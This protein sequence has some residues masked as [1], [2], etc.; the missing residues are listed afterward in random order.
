MLKPLTVVANLT[1]PAGLP[2]HSAAR[3]VFFGEAGD[4]TLNAT[5]HYRVE[6][7]DYAAASDT[8]Y[9]GTGNDSYV[10]GESADRR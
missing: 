10:L 7:N 9:G 5:Y 1:E 4:D 2:T 3:Y 8:L 6:N